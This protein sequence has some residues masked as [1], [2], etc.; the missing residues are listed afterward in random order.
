MYT[1][2]HVQFTHFEMFTG[3]IEMFEMFTDLIE[4]F[5]MFTDLFVLVDNIDS[6]GLITPVRLV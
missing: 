5:E 4:M 1:K 6:A 2:S 3:L